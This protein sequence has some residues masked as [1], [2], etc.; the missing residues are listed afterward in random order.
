MALNPARKG[1]MGRINSS[2]PLAVY[3]QLIAQPWLKGVIEQIRGEKPIA[4]VNASGASGTSDEKNEKDEKDEKA[5][6]KAR[7]ELKKQ[8]PFRAIHYARFLNNHRS[9][10]DADPESFLF[11]TTGDVDDA[12]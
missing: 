2:Q 9:Q 12:E 7:E 8:L 1:N 3:D 11:Q 5:L 6:A 4:G 10:G